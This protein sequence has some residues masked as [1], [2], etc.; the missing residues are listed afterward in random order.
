M[1][2]Y[3][4]YV[5]HFSAWLRSTTIVLP[6]LLT[7]L[8]LIRGAPAPWRKSQIEPRPHEE[9]KGQMNYG[10]MRR[11]SEAYFGTRIRTV[12]APLQNRQRSPSMSFPEP[13]HSRHLAIIWNS[14][15]LVSGTLPGVSFTTSAQ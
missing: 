9:G 5:G 13:E 6:R 7:L 8:R 4:H 2:H 1:G 12:P 10:S 11:V 3:G 14:T 15:L